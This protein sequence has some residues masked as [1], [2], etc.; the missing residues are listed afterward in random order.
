[1]N[2]KVWLNIVLVISL[3]AGLSAQESP[4]G[5][6][7]FMIDG[8]MRL[9]STWGDDF[10]VER[11][12]NF[13]FTPSVMYFPVSS[14]AIGGRINI[15]SYKLYGYKVRRAF[16][17]PQIG[18]YVRMG[19]KQNYI[20]SELSFGFISMEFDNGREGYGAEYG[21]GLG[22]LNFVSKHIAVKGGVE[23]IKQ[24]VDEIN[25]IVF[26]PNFKVDHTYNGHG[27]LDGSITQ[28]VAGLSYFIY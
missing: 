13:V 4:V 6:G 12:S 17:G 2:A 7:T 5:K 1:M 16:L 18:F 3:W 9:S 25:D 14:F 10:T 15:E 22:F 21:V 11:S 23:F 27:D 20:Y 19:K 28:F 24:S 8:S 26:Y